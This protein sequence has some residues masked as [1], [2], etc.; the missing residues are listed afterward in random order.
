[1]LYK[2]THLPAIQRKPDSSVA[3]EDHVKVEVH[4]G[5]HIWGRPQTQRYLDGFTWIN[6]LA[7]VIPSQ[8]QIVR[9][10]RGAPI[11]RAKKKSHRIVSLIPYIKRNVTRCPW[12]NQPPVKRRNRK[13]TAA[14]PVDAHP[15]GL[16]CSV[17]AE[18]CSENQLAQNG[19]KQNHRRSKGC[20][21]YQCQQPNFLSSS[22]E[23]PK[24]GYTTQRFTQLGNKTFQEFQK[25]SL[26]L[27]HSFHVK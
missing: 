13:T 9:S 27:L 22:S 20:Q 24:L 12:V 23:W 1:M 19:V 3:A 8:R 25:E 2:N 15:K 18:S 16:H 11:L 10:A 7:N 26:D 4:Q 17:A 21:Q 14:I 6:G 5:S